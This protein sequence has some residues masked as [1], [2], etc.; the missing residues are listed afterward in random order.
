LNLGFGCP[1]QI[2][3]DFQAGQRP[4]RP[5]GGV[6]LVPP[7]PVPIVQLK[8]VMEVVIPLAQGDQ[9]GPEAIARRVFLRVRLVADRM[10]HGIDGEGRSRTKLY[11]TRYGFN[12]PIVNFLFI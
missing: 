8:L 10:R 7:Y 5:L 6:E 4:D 2:A 12:F 3:S 9:S 11:D 1:T